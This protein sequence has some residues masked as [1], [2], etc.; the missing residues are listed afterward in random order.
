MRALGGAGLLPLGG[1]SILDVGCG[2]GEELAELVDDGADPGRCHGL[3]LLPDRIEVARARHPAMTFVCGDAR[4]LPYPDG[5][6]DVVTANVVFSS[7]LDDE[8]ARAVAREMTRVV[9]AHGA[10]LFYDTRYPSPWNPNVRAYGSTGCAR[11]RRS[12][13]PS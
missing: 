1:R 5:S 4:R 6:F 9:T 12:T 8:V 7:I 13:V 3:D 11:S 2:T 10:I